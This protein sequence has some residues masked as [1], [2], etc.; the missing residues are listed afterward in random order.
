MLGMLV[1]GRVVGR[2]LMLGLEVGRETVGRLELGRETLG[3]VDGFIALLREGNDEREG[4][5]RL[6]L[7]RET[8]R[9]LLGREMLRPP[10]PEREMPPPDRPRPPP[11]AKT[12]AETINT[13][14]AA[15]IATM[16]LFFIGLSL[17]SFGD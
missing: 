17:G 5:E 3:R 11:I 13:T 16:N 9:P 15:A 8:L 12:S 6:G 7:G 10:P 1:L 2:E 4:V 14:R